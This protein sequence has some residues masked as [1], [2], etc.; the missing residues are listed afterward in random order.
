MGEFMGMKKIFATGGL[1]LLFAT[2]LKGGMPPG[3]DAYMEREWRRRS[4][5]LFVE[6]VRQSDLPTWWSMP[7]PKISI[8]RSG[9]TRYVD[10]KTGEAIWNFSKFYYT[11]PGTYGHNATNIP[12]II[13]MPADSVNARKG[14]EKVD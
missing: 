12:Q 5:S 7:D 9:G 2:G 6:A 8:N 3:G 11:Q 14:L 10:P 13:I 1:A 4:D